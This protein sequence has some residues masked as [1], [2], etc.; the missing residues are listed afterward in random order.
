MKKKS[1]H[2]IA[3]DTLRHL[4]EDDGTTYRYQGAHIPLHVLNV[5]PQPRKTFAGIPE[6]AGDVAEKKILNPPTVAKFSREQAERHVTVINTLWGTNFELENLHAASEVGEQD[7][8]YILLAG[9]RRY[10]SCQYLWERGCDSCREQYG[11]EQDGI[12]FFRHFESNTIEVRLCV[13]IPPLPA[14]FLQ[15]SENTHLSVPPHEEAHAYGLLF[16]LIRQARETFSVT[17]FARHV[18]RTPETVRNALR[19]CE[20]PSEI[21]QCVEGGHIRYGMAV[22]IARLQ[23]DGIS[24]TDE[25]LLWTLRAA[26]GHVTTKNFRENVTEY[27]TQ[28]HI[29]QSSFLEL[30]GHGTEQEMRAIRVTV[31]E[32]IIKGVWFWVHY[33]MRVLLLFEQGKLGKEDSLLSERSPVRVFRSFIK[34]L[35]KLLPHVKPFLPQKELVKTERIL[36]EYTIMSDTSGV[37]VLSS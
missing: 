33:C 14:L 18:G 25:L 26:T 16:Q 12:C 20:L 31:A 1:Q 15:L 36:L 23:E 13:D 9:E 35:E 5:L 37:D 30:V 4:L 29:G 27:L 6:L 17:Q 24:D 19:Y 21:Q 8:Y 34:V 32:D 2:P 7:V 3:I 11:E 28:R 22:E 10:R